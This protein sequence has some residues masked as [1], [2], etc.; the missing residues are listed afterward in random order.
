MSKEL[1]PLKAFKKLREQNDF[2]KQRNIPKEYRYDDELDIVETALKEYKGAEKHIEA[3]NK[4]RI[5]NSIKLKALEIIK[6][7]PVVALV[8]YKHTYEEWLELVDEREKDLFKNKEEY[9][10]LKEVLL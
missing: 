10:L 2:L 1:T 6:E 7:K 4:E 5:E 9:N 3:L 8:D